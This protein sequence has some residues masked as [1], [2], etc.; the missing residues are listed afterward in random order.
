MA[1][2]RCAP[3]RGGTPPAVTESAPSRTA[4]EPDDAAKERIVLTAVQTLLNNG[5]DTYGVLAAALAMGQGLG[6][7]IEAVPGWSETALRAKD[8]LVANVPVTPWGVNMRRVVATLAVVEAMSDRRTSGEAALQALL[9]ASQQPAAN[10]WLFAAM[11]GFGTVAL[12]LLNGAGSPNVLA[13]V[14]SVAFLGG[15]LRRWMAGPLGIG[16]GLVQLFAAALLAGAVGG[17]VS[18]LHIAFSSGMLAL[19]PLFVLVPGPALLGGAF[20]L[21]AL[22]LPLGLARF[23]YGLLAIT[24]LCAGVLIG[25]WVGGAVTP[26]PL[27]PVLHLAL[28]QDMVCAGVASAAYA[29]FFSMPLRLLALPV[30]VGMLAHGLRWLCLSKLHFANASAAGLACLL[31][32]II[33]EPI[34][35]R[36]RLPFAA[37]GFAAVVAQV[38]GSFLFRTAAGLVALQRLGGSAPPSLVLDIATNGGSALLTLVA[39]ALGLAIPK[40]LYQHLVARP[41][42]EVRPI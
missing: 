42:G 38:P 26:A 23:T 14:A 25:A 3:G 35:R 17:A 34:A 1:A 20:D 13:T 30:I 8:R 28:W 27:S 39:M 9:E 10:V 18:R 11:C 41:M 7:A 4:S 5:E 12:S 24:A 40:S 29:V 15:L 37:V 32:G 21:M 19:G 16:N 22:R 31:V 36:W 2:E 6:L 33:M